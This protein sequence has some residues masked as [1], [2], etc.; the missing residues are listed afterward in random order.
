MQDEST[1]EQLKAQAA[2][3]LE[4]L[5]EC[6]SSTG[7]MSN[8]A[9]VALDELVTGTVLQTTRIHRERLVDR[10]RVAEAYRMFARDNKVIDA[11]GKRG[12]I[13]PTATMRDYRKKVADAVTRQVQNELKSISL[14]TQY[15]VQ[16]KEILRTPDWQDAL[17]K[18]RHKASEHVRKLIGVADNHRGVDDLTETMA[19]QM[20]GLI[21]EPLPPRRVQ[22]EAAVLSVSL[23]STQ[24]VREHDRLMCSVRAAHDDAVG[25]SPD[26]VYIDPT[27]GIAKIHYIA[28]DGVTHTIRNDGFSVRDSE[29][30]I[31]NISAARPD[32]DVRLVAT[33]EDI[34]HAI[35]SLEIRE[36]RVCHIADFT[37]GHCC[38]VAPSFRNKSKGHQYTAEEKEA[39]SAAGKQREDIM[40]FINRD[41]EYQ[42]PLESV[43]ESTFQISPTL[44]DDDYAYHSW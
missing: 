17:I 20:Q 34:S 30:K 28:T 18:S 2:H 4:S 12:K 42:N 8:W 41:S 43:L 6:F 16:V 13:S 37:R 24:Q 32:E 14:R 38:R 27:S 39:V 15:M 1:E 5:L 31:N 10:C 22:D 11:G 29:F 25:Q 9:A 33:I 7:E 40:E 23:D 26:H 35:E 3:D 19:A 36:D 44:M 21:S